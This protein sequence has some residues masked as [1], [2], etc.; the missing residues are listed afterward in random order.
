MFR[1]IVFTYLLFVLVIS[2]SACSAMQPKNT[3]TPGEVAIVSTATVMATQPVLT[4][5]TPTETP[6]PTEDINLPL[7]DIVKCCGSPVPGWRPSAG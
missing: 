4:L 5:T 2:F 1:K 7:G 3:P 6:F